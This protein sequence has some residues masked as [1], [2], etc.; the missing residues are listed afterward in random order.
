VAWLVAELR[1]HE[2]Q[3]AE[4]LKQRKTHV[5]ERKPLDASPAAITLAMLMSDQEGIGK[6]LLE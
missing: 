6:A 1:G 5:E 4:E 3:A 2:R